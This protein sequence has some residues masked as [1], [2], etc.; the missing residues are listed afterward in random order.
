MKLN[1]LIAVTDVNA[2]RAFYE[3]IFGLEVTEDYGKMVGFDCGLVLQ[4]DFDWLT[5]IPEDQIKKKENNC[6]LCFEE[7]NFDTFIETIKKR[8][9]VKLLHGVF[10][11]TWGQRVIRFYDLDDHLIEVG[12]C[13]KTVTERFLE[14]GMSMEE[15]ARKMDVSVEAVE[16]IL[17]GG[18]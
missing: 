8:R 10:E 9:D 13:M 18:S 12:E 1:Y 14:Q 15:T 17:N 7:P 4:Q 3:E 16:R 5:G 2:S 11:H 6:E